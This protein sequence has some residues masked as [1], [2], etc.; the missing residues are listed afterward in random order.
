[1]SRK[2]RDLPHGAI[3]PHRRSVRILRTGRSACRAKG[4]TYRTGRSPT[5]RSVRILRTGP[6]RMSRMMRDLPHGGSIHTGVTCAFG[7]RGR[8][9][10]RAKGATYGGGGVDHRRTGGIH[11]HRR[12]VRILRT[13][14]IRMS[15]KM[16]DLR[17]GAICMSRQRRDLRDGVDV[18]EAAE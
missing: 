2:M 17:H 7:A 6:I 4:A 14:A 1:M 15:R 18:G 13:G 8:S 3:H 16:R 9:A 5:P 11:P 10:C 12:N